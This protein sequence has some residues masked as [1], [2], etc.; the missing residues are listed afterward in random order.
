MINTFSKVAENPRVRFIGNLSLGRDV[1]LKEIREAY[2]AV[3][4]VTNKFR[5]TLS[6]ESQFLTIISFDFSVMVLSKIEK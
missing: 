4:L 2:N 6:H 3:V 5:F 1:S